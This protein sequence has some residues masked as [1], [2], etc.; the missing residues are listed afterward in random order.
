M[1]VESQN[2]FQGLLGTCLKSKSTGFL[3][4]PETTAI[5][6]NH[7]SGYWILL[8]LA[9]YFGH[10]LLQR[11]PTPLVE[12]VQASDC[13]LTTYLG[14]WSK[15]LHLKAIQ[16]SILSDRYFFQQVVRHMHEFLR[17]VLG[18]YLE[19]DHLRFPIG[20]ALPHSFSPERLLMRL[21]SQATYLGNPKLLHDAPRALF[22]ASPVQALTGTPV[23]ALTSNPSP[24]SDDLMVAAMSGSRACFLCSASDHMA[25][26]CPRFKQIR[27]NPTAFSFFKRQF[28]TSAT[29]SSRS[30]DR[31]MHAL[32]EDTD[33][34]PGSSAGE[35]DSAS[36]A[37]VDSPAP[38]GASREM[39]DDTDPDFP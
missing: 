8:N 23:Q 15:Y 9:Q 30:N 6:C 28:A 5:V 2:R 24:L 17:P 11:S 29:P 39:D 38:P 25:G 37:L 33:V 14:L 34:P 3:S 32:G 35:G 1:Q 22:R 4:L 36:D 31:R 26:S 21:S 13:P 10:P 19:Q 27:D 7:E 20:T 12:P 16:G 18:Q